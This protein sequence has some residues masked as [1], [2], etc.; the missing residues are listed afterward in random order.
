MSKNRRVINKK[1][2]LLRRIDI[3]FIDLPKH[4][5]KL[6]LLLFHLLIIS[7]VIYAF[8]GILIHDLWPEIFSKRAHEEKQMLQF[9][10][11]I[12]L[13]LIPFFIITGFYSYYIQTI[14]HFLDNRS[15][16]IKPDKASELLN[17]SKNLFLTSILS[18][19]LIKIIEYLFKE[20]NNEINI[21]AIL[22]YGA[23]IIILMTFILVYHKV[24]KTSH[25]TEVS[26]DN[27]K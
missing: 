19:S 5:N 6:I 22:S 16:I 2:K 7:S 14:R 25:K 27:E 1:L 15:F 21:T 8:N 3:W 10:E 18:Y 17:I 11:H 4:I 13:Y 26:E 23:F 12:F 20:D 24:H 9:A